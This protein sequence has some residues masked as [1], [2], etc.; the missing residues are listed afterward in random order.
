MDTKAF[1]R[2]SALRATHSH[3]INMLIQQNEYSPRAP[4][5][6]K[7]IGDQQSTPFTNTFIKCF[8][9]LLPTK[10]VIITLRSLSR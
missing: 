6:R 8:A 7:K 1:K 4:K 10:D 2:Q 5:N 3:V 9:D